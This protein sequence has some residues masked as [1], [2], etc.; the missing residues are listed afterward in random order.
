MF[1][2]IVLY[3]IFFLFSLGQLGRISFFNQQINFYL[4]EVFLGLFLL[5]LFF[6][7]RFNPITDAWKKSTSSFIF[8]FILF[9]SLLIGF[10]QYS[11]FENTVGFLYFLRL[12]LYLTYWSY[13]S[14]WSKKDPNC[15]KV[16]KNGIMII[17]VVTIITT[18]TQYLLYPDLRNLFYLGWDPHLY[19]TFGVFFDTAIAGTIYG[20]IFLFSDQFIVKSIF[21]IFLVLSF[22]RS[23]YLSFII[24]LLY[25]FIKKSQFKKLFIYL[26]ILLFL[27]FLLP[28]PAGE[29]VNITRTFS[30]VSRV[31]DYQEGINLF[32]KKPIFG[33]GYN[34]LRYLRNIQGS[35]AG[36]SFSSS[37]LT[38]LVSSGL[39]GLIGLISLMG[40]IWRHSKNA[41]ALIVF[42]GTVSLFDNVLLHPF[43]LF[44]AG[45]LF[46]LFDKKQ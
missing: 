16:L 35:H 17:T 42:L 20:M 33:Y 5:V 23:I 24:A 40:L 41:R 32:L 38:V 30:I 46:T 11:L 14:Y 1:I 43:I 12:S 44:F 21:L 45:V 31:K 36:A 4:Y 39:I 3:L 22:S 28:K 8:L 10:N 6:K 29:G 26:F 18:V 2:N 34:R 9:L 37:Y 7:Y 27:I 19:R 13:L 15:K 25:L